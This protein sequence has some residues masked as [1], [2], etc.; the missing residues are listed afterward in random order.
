MLKKLRVQGFKSIQDETFEFGA[1][2]LLIGGNGSGKSNILEAL[3]LL[4]AV[5]GYE[6]AA[7]EVRGRGVRPVGDWLSAFK[8]PG[9]A[10][11]LVLEATCS[12]EVEY[13]C[14]LVES[15][16]IPNL[17]IDKEEILFK[18][19]WFLRRANG[20]VSLCKTKKKRDVSGHPQRGAWQLFRE[21]MDWP[22]EVVT[23]LDLLFR[24]VIFE[25]QTEMLRGLRTEM[26]SVQPFGIKGGMV[27]KKSIDFNNQPEKSAV[28]K[29]ILESSYWMGSFEEPEDKVRVQ[30]DSAGNLL[31]FKDKFM[32]NQE[33]I[34]SFGCN[35]GDLYLTFVAATLLHPDAPQCF[36]MENVDST[37]NPAMA[38]QMLEE[39]IAVVR[40]QHG[41]QIGPEQI[42]LTTHHPTALD[43][44][45]LFD[46][47]QRVFVVE[48]DQDGAT[49]AIRL[50]PAPGW[51][52]VD[53]I[54][55]ASGGMLSEL[56][57]QGKIR[58]ALSPDTRSPL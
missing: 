11:R 52:R 21:A 4:S 39:V 22:K 45:D 6:V 2:N 20:K 55:F 54:R 37:L 38:R 57:I 24:F 9:P 44:V 17:Q 13:R 31:I 18:G 29:R 25:P 50:Q 1:V 58:G 46:D 32:T 15:K 26:G 49:H 34:S 53:W 10:N 43:A 14:E 30:E 3:G 19:E 40:K 47:E 36:A 7:R 33:I 5:L 35:E 42:F 28:F 41:A 51:T 23:Q 8:V 12:D 27:S 16:V 56:W 48:R